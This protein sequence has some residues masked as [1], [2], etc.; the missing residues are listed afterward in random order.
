MAPTLRQRARWL[1]EHPA[2]L[3]ALV[4]ALS[5]VGTFAN[6]PVLDDGWVIFENP[7]VKRL[8]QVG[9]I[10]RA[11]YHAAGAATNAGLWRPVT[12]L[13]Y[14]LNYAAGGRAVG[15]Y[16][17]V[18]ALL[19]VAV[20]LLVLALARRVV[21][22]V[23]PERARAS[24]ALAALLF[25][26]HPVHVEAV[27]GMVGRAELLAALAVLGALHL[28]CSRGGRRWRLPAAL[29][30]AAL[31][32]LAKE[33]AVVTPL[34]FALLALAAPGAAGL[35]P[36]PGLAKGA[37]R[38]ALHTAAALTAA[39]AGAVAIPLLLRPVPIG[40][41]AAASW[42]AGRPPGVVAGTMARA[43]AEYLR[44]LVFPLELGVDFF[45]A[46]RIPFTPATAPEAI[47]AALACGA[48]LAVGL[49][50]L[51][52]APV[53][54]LGIVW[55]FVALLPVANVVPAGVLMAERLLYLPSV[56]FCLW[57]GHGLA[58]AA[59]AA[60]RWA[61]ARARA[62]AWCAGAALLAA[63]GARTLLRN[64]DWHDART[65]WRAE[66][67]HAP[68]DPVVN[69]NLAVALIQSGD[70]DDARARLL[71][72]LEVASGYWRAWVNVGILQHRTGDLES[73]ARSFARAAAID[74]TAP[75][76][77]Y[78]AALALADGGDLRGAVDAL[79][80]AEQLAP[81]DAEVRYRRGTYLLRLGLEEEGVAE[82]RRAAALDP[83]HEPARA[84]L[85]GT[86]G[87]G[88]AK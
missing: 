45:Y 47:R 33:N 40:A 7:L 5:Q 1:G 2:L 58:W 60:H 11:P 37:P 84:T 70:Y 41:P 20:A 27:G 21:A 15:G 52:R 48:V 67:R 26:V 43:R 88:G 51:R 16:H 46:A 65:L 24:A 14:A 66:L 22:A 4:A 8:D 17:L 87:A 73:A 74:P 28:V 19:H 39:L 59:Q 68:R 80:R 38:R 6:Q 81:E 34:L 23:A 3:V 72:T 50:S 57:A 55:I 18:N 63:L 77:H 61:G 35:A 36:R 76:P 31:G 75:S 56:G 85:A 83:R 9:R 49:A 64:R 32:V 71:T 42:F 53:R 30:A 44:L 82:L 54:G 79:A 13:S 25:A 29:A 10:L 62:M 78:F 12:T 69:N 86:T